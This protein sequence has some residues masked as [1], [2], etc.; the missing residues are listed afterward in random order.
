MAWEIRSGRRVYYRSRRVGQQV[1]RDYFSGAEAQLAAAIDE[2]RRRDR[3]TELEKA[4]SIRRV[5]DDAV[6]P[7]DVLVATGNLLNYANRLAVA[8][9]PRKDGFMDAADNVIPAE[10]YE[11]IGRAEHGDESVLPRMRE[12]LDAQPS[13]AAA[14]GDLGRRCEET[15]IELIAGGDVFAAEVIRRSLRSW[16]ADL[17]GPNPPSMI[18]ILVD[19]AAACWVQTEYADIVYAQSMGKGVSLIVRRELERQRDGS[20]KRL[21]TTLKQLTQTQKFF[22]PAE[23]KTRTQIHEPSR[24]NSSHAPAAVPPNL[25]VDFPRLSRTCEADALA[26][27]TG[28]L[29]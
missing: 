9:S 22:Q 29:N 19:Q 14:F 27:G 7:L 17:A 16:R 11:L 24:P 1:H 12:L 15:W 3:R 28:V 25:A 2:K 23:R 26:N 18:R 21:L 20:R 6:K 5:W 13:I 8:C 10:L 4:R